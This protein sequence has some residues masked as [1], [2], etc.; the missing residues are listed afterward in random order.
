MK[1]CAI[2][3]LNYNG[4]ETLREFLPDVVTLSSYDVWIIDNCSTDSSIGYVTSD[5]PSVQVIRLGSNLGYAGGYNAGLETLKGKYRNYILLNS[6]VAVSES[7]DVKLCSF[8]EAREEFAAVQP[9]ILSYQDRTKFDYAGAGG[10]FLDSLGYPYCRGRLWD[11]IEEDKG[12]YDDEQEVDWA[13]GACLVIKS[14]VFHDCGGFDPDFF[15]HMEEIDLCWRMRRSRWKIG[16]LGEVTVYHLGGATLT[17]GSAKKLYLNIRNS[18]SMLYKNESKLKFK[19]IYPIKF[20]LEHMAA[21]SYLKNG[22]RELYL[23][24]RK[25][26]RDFRTRKPGLYRGTSGSEDRSGFKKNG[27]SRFIFW[28]YYVLRRKKYSSL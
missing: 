25:G 17:R 20:F 5:F 10:G 3:I 27:P 9:K 6:D 28:D 21:F 8:L 11:T 24:I 14:S 18:L 23:A 7:W 12:Q 2:V 26:Y 15:A 22:N 13:S 16:Y 19:L 1:P 4:E